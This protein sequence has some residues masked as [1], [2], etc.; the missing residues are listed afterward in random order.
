MTYGDDV[1]GS[2]RSGYDW[3]N[4]ISV[5]EFFGQR[6]IVFTPPNKESYFTT[7]YMDDKDA[8]FLKRH[9]IFNVVTGLIHG[10]LDE[11]SIFKSLHCV[12]ESK[13]VSLKQQA[14]SNIDG[15]LREWWNHGPE[16]YELRRAQMQQIAFEHEIHD[17]CR[18][19]NESYEDGLVHFN[20]R[21][22]GVDKEEVIEESTFVSTVGDDWD[23][24]E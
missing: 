10:A 21:Y 23:F 13:V 1:K 5:A 9:N 16:V 19:L 22:I 18:M 2:V 6:D 12:L 7:E 24:E 17:F 8:D 14:I 3:Y 20:Q 11:T 15:A 4:N